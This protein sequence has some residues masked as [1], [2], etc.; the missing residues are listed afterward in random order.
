M[1]A[2]TTA[3]NAAMKD[4]AGETTEFTLE[5][6]VALQPASEDIWDKNIA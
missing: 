1:S 2:S 3:T 5:T 6:E 4:T